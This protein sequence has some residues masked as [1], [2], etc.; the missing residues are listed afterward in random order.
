MNR[1]SSA[2]G[3]SPCAPCVQSRVHGG[4]VAAHAWAQGGYE[5][6]T[7]PYAFGVTLEQ[8]DTLDRLVQSIAAHGDVIAASHAAVLHP[9]TLP[10]L[11]AAAHDAAVSSAYAAGSGRHAAALNVWQL[12]ARARWRCDAMLLGPSSAGRSACGSYTN[13]K[14]KR[15]FPLAPLFGYSGKQQGQEV[16]GKTGGQNGPCLLQ[17]DQ[18]YKTRYRQCF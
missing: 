3:A 17:P 8:A 11:G 5:M 18:C 7:M 2:V 1:S 13:G 10:A 14:F 16:N 6:A 4:T 15:I 9:A 12:C